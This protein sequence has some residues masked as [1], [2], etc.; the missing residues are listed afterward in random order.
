MTIKFDLRLAALGLATIGLGACAPVDHGYGETL[1]YVK[2]AQT[3]NPDPVYPEGGA[4]P[5]DN[6]DVA[7]AAAERYRQG[8]VKQPKAVRSTSGANGGGGG[9]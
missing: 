8:D 4:E 3:V 9:G 5:G 2:A 6:G 7:A 1:A